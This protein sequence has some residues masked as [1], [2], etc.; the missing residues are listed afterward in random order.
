[1]KRLLALLLAITIIA[2][3]VSAEPWYKDKKVW[4]MIGGSIGSSLMA[5]YEAHKCREKFGPAPCQGGYGEFKVREIAR[6]TT[7]VGMDA[8]SIWGRHQGFK[9]WPI[10]GV[11]FAS[12]NTYVAVH[13]S[14]IGCPAGQEFVYG[15]KFS[16]QPS[17]E[18][19][20]DLSKIEFVPKR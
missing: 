11:G 20:P 15:T 12:Y 1:M 5:T 3:A 8:I 18:W 16:C 6:L 14:Q 17:D 4:G 9:E 7:S 2:P 13:E 10:W 19:K